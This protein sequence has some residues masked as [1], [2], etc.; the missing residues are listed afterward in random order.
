MDAPKFSR[1]FVLLFWVPPP[2][3]TKFHESHTHSKAIE[4]HCVI[5]RFLEVKQNKACN[6]KKNF[7]IYTK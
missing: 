1:H 4:G 7:E 2:S 6:Y 3:P 5:L